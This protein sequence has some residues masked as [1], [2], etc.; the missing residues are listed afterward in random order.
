MQAGLKERGYAL[1]ERDLTSGIQMLLVT[2]QGILGG[3]DPRR[4]GWVAGE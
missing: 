1:Q 4:E 3:A 2:P